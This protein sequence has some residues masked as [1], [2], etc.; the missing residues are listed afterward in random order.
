MRMI[1]HVKN[2][3]ILQHDLP[4]HGKEMIMKSHGK[5]GH[6]LQHDLPLHGKEMIMKSHGKSGH[7]LQHDLPLLGKEI[8]IKPRGKSGMFPPTRNGE[9]RIQDLLS[10]KEDPIPA[11][12]PKA[13]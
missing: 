5:S 7:I 9:H 8:I 2:G 4:L 6:I 1:P 13:T 10:R 3:L 12:N 11:K